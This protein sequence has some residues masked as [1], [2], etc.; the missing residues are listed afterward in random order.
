MSS[1]S[2]RAITDQEFDRYYRAES[3][4]FGGHPDEHITAIARSVTELDRTVVAFDGDEI[5]GTSAAYSFEMTFPGGGVAPVAGV[6]DVAV[7]PTH[8]RRGI[9]TEML[10]RLHDDA[11][12]R[13]EVA[14]VLTA[15]ESVIY[16]R[17]GYGRAADFVTWSIDTRDVAFRSPPPPPVRL[18]LVPKDEAGKVLADLYDPYRLDRPGS[19]SRR[20]E[21]WAARLADHRTWKGGGAVFV[22]VAEPERGRGETHRP[23][24]AATSSTRWR[25][26]RKGSSSGSR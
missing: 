13:G 26:P 5:V 22:A 23:T 12:G 6:A 3:A 15:S 20:P 24:P 9:L 19:L 18:R 16:G 1:L 17:F 8:R 4:A 10:R 21:W 25:T 7:L 2:F 14:A 11:A